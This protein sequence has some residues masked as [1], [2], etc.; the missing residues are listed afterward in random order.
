MDRCSCLIYSRL[1]G[2]RVHP[3]NGMKDRTRLLESVLAADVC[4]LFRFELLSCRNDIAA[5]LWPGHALNGPIPCHLSD[6]FSRPDS[7]TPE[8]TKKP[9]KDIQRQY[10]NKI[11]VIITHF[12]LIF[13]LEHH[14]VPLLERLYHICSMAL[15][16]NVSQLAQFSHFLTAELVLLFWRN[17]MFSISISRLE[18]RDG[19]LVR[20]KCAKL[21]TR[22]N[23]P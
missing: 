21:H 14:K 6:H 20:S 19:T 15:S 13:F 12:P 18:N 1:K 10:K 23:K 7:L 11:A 22:K 16:V 5:G 2:A 3:G 8:E 17:C 9:G 4:Q